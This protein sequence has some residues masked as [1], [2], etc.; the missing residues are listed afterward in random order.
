M[1]AVQCAVLWIAEQVCAMRTVSGE[2]LQG[3]LIELPVCTVD[4]VRNRW[5]CPYGLNGLSSHTFVELGVSNSHSVL[6]VQVQ[7]LEGVHVWHEADAVVDN[8]VMIF[9]SF[10]FF[11]S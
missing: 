11:I 2:S 7:G 6:Y 1:I 3:T 5:P 8:F 10:L 4:S 9:L